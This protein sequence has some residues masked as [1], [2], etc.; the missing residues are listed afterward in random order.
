M[1][2]DREKLTADTVRGKSVF[3]VGDNEE[4]ENTCGLIINTWKQRCGGEALAVFDRGGSLYEKLGEDNL[5][6]DFSSEGSVCPDF[7]LS[8]LTH[9]TFGRTP[10]AASDFLRNL[11]APEKT[12]RTSNDAFW[13]S[14]SN[15]T[16]RQWMEYGLA[17]AIEDRRKSRDGGREVNLSLSMA[18]HSDILNELMSGGPEESVVYAKMKDL[19]NGKIDS[20]EFFAACGKSLK[21]SEP[22]V[23]LADYI[24]SEHPGGFPFDVMLGNSRQ[25]GSA[26]TAVNVLRT[27]RSVGGNFLRFMDWLKECKPALDKLP[28]LNLNNFVRAPFGK[29]L[30][31]CSSG[32]KP[33]DAAYASETFAALAAAADTEGKD[34]TV[35]MPA[36]D[37]WNILRQI[38]EMRKDFRRFPHIVIGYS[39]L[40]AAERSVPLNDA[41]FFANMDELSD[42]AI[43]HKSDDVLLN[44]LFAQKIIDKDAIYGPSDL[45]EGLA[46]LKGKYS[47]L[48]YVSAE[49]YYVGGKSVC[50]RVK[51]GI[52]SS[53]LW[54]EK[55][56]G[57]KAA[58]ECRDMLKRRNLAMS[59]GLPND[60]ADA[61]LKTGLLNDEQLD[62]MKVDEAVATYLIFTLLELTKRHKLGGID[63]KEMLETI[64]DGK[65]TITER[66]EAAFDVESSSD[67]RIDMDGGES[68]PQRKH[69]NR[70]KKG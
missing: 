21:T 24:C 46:A 70:K 40:Q 38:T 29:I 51:L 59:F 62:R 9:P 7:I 23:T 31:I 20:K 58:K 52:A 66:E 50:R 17:L 11:V 42:A 47:K 69:A 27:V 34:V 32:D 53:T 15:E 67:F 33:A 8:L 30:F 12:D 61:V 13:S 55:A 26:S 57:G 36:V 54:I 44:R 35:L 65:F 60:L 6:A 49:P 22:Y 68:W 56:S 4:K 43:W 14:S 19:C 1:S 28:T 10:F 41:E 39:N 2:I 18:A 3:L 37:D 25:G 5:L 16:L 45:G 63:P 48:K 64:A